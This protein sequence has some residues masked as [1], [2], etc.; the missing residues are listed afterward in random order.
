MYDIKVRAAAIRFLAPVAQKS[1]GLAIRQGRINE[2]RFESSCGGYSLFSACGAK[3]PGLSDPAWPHKR[4]AIREF[5]R[6]L[7]AFLRLRRRK[8]RGLASWYGRIRRFAVQK[9][10]R[11]CVCGTE[12]AGH[13][14]QCAAQD[15]RGLPDALGRPRFRGKG[16]AAAHGRI[17]KSERAY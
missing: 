14:R 11:L 15:G 4:K 17:P 16:C 2:K 6:R 8:H 10:V 9:A 5:V 13:M 7:F 3:K 1:R 12:N